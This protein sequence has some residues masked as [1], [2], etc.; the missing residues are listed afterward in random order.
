MCST[1]FRSKPYIPD[2]ASNIV[3]IPLTLH[4]LDSAFRSKFSGH[5]GFRHEKRADSAIP[6]TGKP[7]SNTSGLAYLTDKQ[8]NGFVTVP[9]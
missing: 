7:P 8:Y 5:S 6:P 3:H 2:S 9:I 4:T 1:T